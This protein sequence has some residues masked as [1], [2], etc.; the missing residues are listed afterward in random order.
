MIFA[1]YPVFWIVALMAAATANAQFFPSWSQVTESR[2]ATYSIDLKTLQFNDGFHQVLVLENFRQQD[3]DGAT[4]VRHSLE[5]DC[6]RNRY[7]SLGF[8]RIGVNGPI[9]S[10]A[11]FGNWS[12]AVS[13]KSI[14]AI[15]RSICSHNKPTALPSWKP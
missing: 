5:F 15:L 7:R 4:S 2:S 14:E 3:R 9:A 11:A 10:S 8:W 13:D 6:S 12:N 1:I